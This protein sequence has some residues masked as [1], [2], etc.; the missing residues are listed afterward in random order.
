MTD[1]TTAAPTDPGPPPPPPPGMPTASDRFYAW[2][3]DFGV[4][5]ADGWL[6]GVCAGIATRL[7]IDP[8][9]VRGIVVVA[10]ILG[11]PMLLL[12]AI[13]WALLP[14]ASGRI[15][16]RELFRGRFDPAI[17]GIGILVVVSFVPVV[18]WL[19]G[20]LL[21]SWWMPA[22]VSWT[23]GGL[24]ATLL[25]LALVVGVVFLV[26]RSSRRD[27]TSG[28]PASASR[29]ASAAADAP[30][31][32]AAPDGT[33]AAALSPTLPP[34]PLAPERGA[35]NAEIAAWR[36]RH[37]A[38]RAQNDAWRR[39][40]QD[41]DRVARDRARAET[42]A[43]NAAFAAE[44]DQRRQVERMSRPRASGAF[45]LAALGAALLIGAAA[46]LGSVATGPDTNG[47]FAG[48]IG[49]F[50]AA[51]VLAVAMVV[52]G[53]IRRR[54][55]FLAFVTILTLV[56]GTV[57]A[58]VPPVVERIALQ[59]VFLSNARDN[60]PLVQPDGSLF[61]DVEPG[62][63]SEHPIVVTKGTGITTIQVWPGAAV[64]LL[65]KI[66]DTIVRTEQFDLNTGETRGDR[67]FPEAA[68][69]GGGVVRATISAPTEPVMTTQ[70]I[71]LTQADGL[72][73]V[74]LMLDGPLPAPVPTATPLPNPEETP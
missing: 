56:G 9:I 15:H 17:V 4:V 11:L 57:A 55:G 60:A 32:A 28:D 73:T 12:Y 10:A 53:A 5:R 54:S 68:L 70:E 63:P 22:W 59:N 71:V 49:L 3:R 37:D 20:L 44:A 41:A 52:A 35:G 50:A 7:R 8:A 6:G 14:D 36:A 66:G 46:S 48:A 62:P 26:A 40:Q 18:P 72:I 58:I 38:W 30:G 65:A 67:L 19:G 34:E 27:Q 69:G 74:R 39:Q 33:G 29:T 43:A 23:P 42:A 13:A 16:V 2:V 24:L 47:A 64:N 45:V 31:P 61:V 21:P 25:G 1:P 51:L